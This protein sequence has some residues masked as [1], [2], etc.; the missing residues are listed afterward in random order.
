MLTR[1]ITVSGTISAVDDENGSD[2]HGSTPV[3]GV[4]LVSHYLPS[5]LVKTSLGVGGEVR[6]ELELH[7]SIAD[8]NFV[9]IQ[10]VSKLFEG[11][12][13]DTD[14]L[15]DE[16]SI[17]L[18][19]A[20]DALTEHKIH[21]VNSGLGG[22]DTADIVL[23]FTNTEGAPR[24]NMP[25]TVEVANQERAMRRQKLL[26]AWALNFRYKSNGILPPWEN[27]DGKDGTT[28]LRQ[29]AAGM[30]I[31][32]D[33]TRTY[34]P[35]DW[36]LFSG[37]PIDRPKAEHQEEFKK[38]VKQYFDEQVRAYKEVGTDG[39]NGKQKRGDYDFVLR[40]II[41]LIH[42]FL[43]KPDI[44][45]NEMIRKLIGQD[46][47]T[48]SPLDGACTMVGQVPFAGQ[49][50]DEWLAEG[51]GGRY[52]F[53]ERWP[54]GDPRLLAIKIS[55]PETENH[56]LGI[57]VWRYLVNEY[58]TYVASL[59]PTNDPYKRFDPC[60]KALVESD[61]VRYKNGP[62]IMDWVLQLLGR[63]PHSGLFESNAKPYE[64]VSLMAL[65][66]FYQ[67]ADR[68]FPQDAM[69][70]K[71]KIAAQNALDYIAAEFAF[72]SFE[73]KRMAPI[74]RNIDHQDNVGFYASDYL[75]NMFGVLTGAY[76]YSDENGA[77]NTT[78]D[79]CSSG[80]TAEP[81][82]AT[83]YHWSA[84]DQNGGFAL[85]S[86]LS[87]YKVPH[88]IHDFMLNKHGGYMARVQTRYSSQ[89][90]VP[91]R[92]SQDL[93]TSYPLDFNFVLGFTGEPD[94]PNFARPRYFQDVSTGAVAPADYDVPG[95]GRFKPVTQ[96]YFATPTYLNSA[97]G[98]SGDYYDLEIGLPNS[99]EEAF[100][101]SGNLK[102]AIHGY[103]LYSRPLTLIPKGNL[104]I[105]DKQDIA[106]LERLLPTMRGQDAFQFSQNLTTYKSFSLGYTFNPDDD[107]RHLDWPQR[108]PSAW[109]DFLV[110]RIGIG[111]AA[112]HIFDFTAQPEHPLTGQ[113]WVLAQFS[114]SENKGQFRHYGRGFWEVVP[115][116][117]FANASALAAH[118]QESNPAS[119]FDNDE[120][121]H[122]HYRLASTG[123]RVTI[124]N[125]FGSSATN[126]A[127]LEIQ[128]PNGDPIPLNRY[129][130]DLRNEV[131]LRQ[132]PLMDV[133]QVDRDYK[134]TGMKYAYGDGHGRVMI[135]N[136]FLGETLTLDSSDYRSPFRT[137]DRA[138]L[139]AGQ[140]PPIDGTQGQIPSVS[141]L[142]LDQD[143]IYAT[144]YF[145]P[146]LFQHSL[147]PGELVALD[148]HTLEPIQRVTVGKSPHA[149]DL[150]RAS[151]RL[152]VVN[153]QDI[154]V[155]VVDA[156]TF[157]V[158]KTTTFPG[159]ALIEVA[160]SQKY[161][162]IFVTQPGQK[163]IIVIDG[164]TLTELSSITN[165]PTVTAV[166][167]EEETDRLYA[168]AYNG[169][170]PSRQDL[171]EFAIS[172][173]GQQELRRTTID[174]QVS[175]FSEMAVDANRIY[176]IN[177]DPQIAGDQ[178]HQKLTVLDRQTLTVI[179]N[180][181]LKSRAGLGVATCLSQHVVYVTTQYHVLVI[182]AHSLQVLRTIQH[183]EYRTEAYQ[184]KGSV[185]V[186]QHNGT[187]YFGGAGSS[188][189]VRY[190]VPLVNLGQ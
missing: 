8:N 101:K 178:N 51:P 126:Q 33:T 150:H 84:I 166:V 106:A 110:E 151:K 11:T 93:Q 68:L 70:Q 128:S 74:R 9:R 157:T 171:I 7:A 142:L 46:K 167:V 140:L 31:F 143:V 79:V 66:A 64:S 168:V 138:G 58:L 77:A 95:P 98:Q 29:I 42:I 107:D 165:L 91:V 184:P 17:D 185:V 62:E 177:K 104:Q 28:A 24:R 16:E 15:E 145:V 78:A 111:R 132:L 97:G 73:S 119:H 20:P 183:T 135:H 137:L 153:Y 43:A 53:R 108:Y 26:R 18:Q 109:D 158:L 75:A 47:V 189:L 105:F 148:R 94:N 120:D 116:H 112:I 118:I 5:G 23:S 36:A 121:H 59:T 81:C 35:E 130:A 136:P 103:D 85:W 162:R 56:Q 12:S 57:Y 180:I 176:V 3:N 144:H 179:D 146:E 32:A 39:L 99:L 175:V 4:A 48:F 14:D 25:P 186:D 34:K 113:Y 147:Q 80:A 102:K 134:F 160:V 65:L 172:E 30:A 92:D 124:H 45:T 188:H 49:N 82:W 21:L 181:P 127:I 122:Y 159:F 125:R 173:Q 170:D 117:Q 67:A 169:A 44:L 83:P 89:Q 50:L 182:D 133:W 86:M 71:I 88:C 164:Q 174:G 22:G 190:G 90:E 19:I 27:E 156:E 187:A 2:E 10:G 87:G 52:Y 152:Y 129:I 55:T 163:R 131:G 37:L 54:E 69:R 6:V 1:K 139:I 114:K 63:I 155:T 72:Q 149:I 100:E 161:N 141:A 154:S 40:D 13:V 123:E 76:V 41:A 38:K 60:L 96:V 61:P 115:G